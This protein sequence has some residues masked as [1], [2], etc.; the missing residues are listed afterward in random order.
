MTIS[1]KE[2]VK[3]GRKPETLK[4][5]GDWRKAVKGALQ[6]KRPEKGWPKPSK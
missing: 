1:Q 4:I 5:A 2:V 3:R 6:K